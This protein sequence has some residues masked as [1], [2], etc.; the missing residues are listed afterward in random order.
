MYHHIYAWGNNRQAIFI[1][2]KHYE[3]YLD[4]L[5]EYSGDNRTDIIAYA[6]MPTHVHLFVYDR[7]DRVSHFMNSLHGE[8][9][10]YFNHAMGRVGH[11]FG[12]RFNSK[13]VQ[14]N[15]YGLWLSR[16]IHRQAVE[17]GT[18]VDPEDYPWTSYRAYIGKAPLDFLKP[19]LILDQFGSGQESMRYYGAFVLSADHGPIDW[20]ARSVVVVADE[21]YS[22]R[23]NERK[24]CVVQ[25]NRSDEEILALIAER[26]AIEHGAMIAPHGWEEK[27]LRR[28]V[29]R[30]LVNEIGLKPRRVMQLLHISRMTV[31]GAFTQK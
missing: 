15:K 20:D 14:A 19:G 2:E 29:I 27:R 11:V 18:V 31:Q 10:Q 26:F 5:A 1:D 30:Y 22:R 23:V 9:A 24:R 16:Y 13:V 6:L 21:D 25:S 3:K 7:F 8:Y 17:N 28:K 4:L 12:E